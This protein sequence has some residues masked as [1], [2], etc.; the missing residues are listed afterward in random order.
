MAARETKVAKEI[1]EA[2]V[3]N[4]EIGHVLLAEQ[5]I[6]Q[7]ETRASSVVRQ[8]QEA[9]EAEGRVT[10][11]EREE[12]KNRSLE[13]G[14]VILAVPITGLAITSASNAGQQ[15]RAEAA[16][17]EAK[18]GEERSAW[19]WRLEVKHASPTFLNYC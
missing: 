15:S 5:I 12:A 10:K 2:K 3:A 11:V 17:A 4:L 19:H 18:V 14:H 6:L 1:R 13:I 8:S 7:I 9:A 16:A